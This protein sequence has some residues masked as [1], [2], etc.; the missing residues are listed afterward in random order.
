MVVGSIHVAF[1]NFADLISV[2]N[3]RSFIDTG[4]KMFSTGFLVAIVV[5]DE[6]EWK[7]NMILNR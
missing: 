6:S 7:T 3:T 5:T 4:H 1:R 2:S